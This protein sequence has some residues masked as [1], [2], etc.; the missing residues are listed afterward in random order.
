MKIVKDIYT[1]QLRYQD[2]MLTALVIAVAVQKLMNVANVVAMA[3]VAVKLHMQSLHYNL[4]RRLLKLIIAVT[5]TFM[6]F[7]LYTRVKVI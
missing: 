6:V 1:V 5:L 3:A 7:N 4:M 2:L